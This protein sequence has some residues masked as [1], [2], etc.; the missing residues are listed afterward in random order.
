VWR[1]GSPGRA[2]KHKTIKDIKIYHQSWLI[3]WASF[4]VIVGTVLSL[5]RSGFVGVEWLVVAVA[6]AIVS[7]KNKKL[8][9]I[10][11]AIMAGLVFGLWRG[12]TQIEAQ[13]GYQNYYNETVVAVGQVRE[14]PSINTDGDI[15]L[16][17]QDVSINSESIGG[18]LWVSLSRSSDIKRSDV[19]E[20]EGRL[21]KGFGNIPAAMFRARVV[22]V[23]RQDYVDV[24]RDTRDWYAEG[25]RQAIPEPEASLGAG[26]L[27]GQKT[28]LPENLDNQ[29]RLLGLTHVVVASGYNLTILIRFSRRFFERISRFTALASSFALVFFFLQITGN[30][31]SMARAS[32]IAGLSL[33][34]WYYGRKIHP[35]V[36]ISFSAA[37]TVAINP[38]YAWGDLGWLLSFASFVGV[39]ML[40]PLV[41]AYF[42]G[43]NKP[44]NVRQVV[45]ETMSAQLMTLPL[46]AF[47]F[48]QYSPLSLIA[49]V[50]VLPLIPVAMALTAVAGLAGVLLPVG[51]M[52]V[53]LPA[54]FLLRYMTSVVDY[55]AQLPLASTEIKFSSS[56]MIIGYVL[57]LLVMIY[58]WRRTSFKFRDYNVIE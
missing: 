4:G 1:A 14:D 34:A 18:E 40:G 17:L 58:M 25:I 27:L 50:L 55:L 57:I 38:A 30:S 54:Y 44:G 51:A 5:Y 22:S 37:V 15:R 45:V 10:F 2:V 43:D 28:A 52:I 7:F 33:L 46:I 35:L 32:L 16:R 24:G 36:L 49:N 47:T 9:A 19:V 3:A 6:L 48:G 53:G 42:W 13:S 56:T 39:I 8:P 31:P 11:L 41:N 23:Q 21:T 12:G 20:V 29:L 26:F